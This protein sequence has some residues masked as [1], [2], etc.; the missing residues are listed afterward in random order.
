MRARFLLRRRE[1]FAYESAIVKDLIGFIDRTFNTRAER[2]GRCIG[3][4]SMGGYGAIKLALQ[5]PDLFASANG[6]SGAY[7]FAH[8]AG[9]I[10]KP[11]SSALLAPRNWWQR[12][13]F[14][15]LRQLPIPP[16]RRPSARA[17]HDCGTTIF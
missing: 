1:G 8:G 10:S 16:R 2:A 15:A 13:R 6:H 7:G 4:L 9:A 11:N 14:R 5:H 12:R 3:G 17:S